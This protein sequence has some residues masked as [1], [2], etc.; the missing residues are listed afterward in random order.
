MSLFG[1]G[2]GK[3]YVPNISA[4]EQVTAQGIFDAFALLD[5]DTIDK[6]KTLIHAVDPKKVEAFMKMLE[7]GTDGKLHLNIDLTISK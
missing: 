6:I 5:K 4:N 1:F 3:N 7:V 2:S